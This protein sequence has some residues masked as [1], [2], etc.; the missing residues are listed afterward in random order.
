MKR[1]LASFVALALSASAA[2][3]H[4]F[5]L[6]NLEIHHPA[7]R[8]TLPGQPVGGGF[9][10]ITNKGAEAD[11]LVS[12]AAPDVSDDVQLHEMAVENDVMKMRQLPDGIEIP[13]GAKVELKSGGLHVMFMRIKHPFTEG[14]KFK[15]TLTFEKAGKIDV[16]FRIEAAKPGARSGEGAADH[17]SHGG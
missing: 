1:I 15:A 4:D 16:D 2:F 17:G 12:I 9:M 3:A 5:T 6:G 8:A 10:T 7:S 13:A 11:R 14:E